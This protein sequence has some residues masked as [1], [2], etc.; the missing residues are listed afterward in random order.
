MSK[1]TGGKQAAVDGTANEYL[2]QAAL[3]KRYHN[4]SKNDNPGG[5]YDLIIPVKDQEGIE[6]FIRAQVKTSRTSV[7]FKSGSRGGIDREYIS[8]EKV[9]RHSTKTAD[10]IIGIKINNNSFDLYFVPTILIELLPHDSI[11]LNKIKDLKNNYD[12]LENCTNKEYVIENCC[13]FGIMFRP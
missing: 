2:V 8:D 12:M 5:S 1:D 4:T 9:Y 7:N 3:M 6:H 13:R 10:V 11:S